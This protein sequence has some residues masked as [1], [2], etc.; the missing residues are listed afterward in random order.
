MDD[1][2]YVQDH[3]IPNARRQFGR[4][5]QLQQDNDPKHKSRLTQQFLSSEVAEVIDSPSNNPAADLVDNLWLIIQ[6]RV[7]KR[8]PTNLEELSKFLHEE[9]LWS[10]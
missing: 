10:S 6:R 2:D 8:K 5:W 3:L 7:E 4:R 1:S 9:W